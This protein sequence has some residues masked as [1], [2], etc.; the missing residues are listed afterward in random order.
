[1]DFKAAL[2]VMH[3]LSKGTELA[4]LGHMSHRQAVT[5][6]MSL[7]RGSSS[8]TGLLEDLLLQSTLIKEII[9]GSSRETGK[10]D[11]KPGIS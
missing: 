6:R 7:W 2:L 1:M 8:S 3:G 5:Q 10:M 9:R 11:F 4:H